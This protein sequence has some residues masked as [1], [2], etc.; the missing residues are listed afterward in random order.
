VTESEEVTV[1]QILEEEHP[2][3]EVGFNIY[4]SS[5][6]PNTSTNQGKPQSIWT[7][8]LCFTNIIHINFCFV[9]LGE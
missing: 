5:G 4:G 7:P 8:S 2:L 6:V 1:D 9:H 3:V